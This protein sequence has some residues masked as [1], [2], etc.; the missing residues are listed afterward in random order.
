MQP[1]YLA[2]QGHNDR[3]LQ[4][5]Y[6][7]LVCRI[8]ADRYGP[9]TLPNPPRT[10]EPVRVGIV[11]GFFFEHSVW[12]MPLKGWLDQLDHRRFRLFGYHTGHKQD[13]ETKAGAAFCERFVAGPLSIG[14][15]RQAILADAPHVLIYPELGMDPTCPQLAAQRLAR[16]QCTS[17]GHPDTSGFPTVDYYL[18]SDP[19][20]PADAQEHYTERLVRLPHLSSYYEPSDI[21]QATTAPPELAL[22]PTATVYLS[23]QSLFKYLPQFD[24]VFPDIAREAGDCQFVFLENRSRDVTELFRQRLQRAFAASGLQAAD[25]CL[26]MPRLDRPRFQAVMSRCHVFLDSIG[27]S[28]CN[29]ALE[30]LAYNLPLVTLPGSLMRGRHVMAM[31][32]IMGIRDTIGQTIADYIAI[33]ARLAR[34]LSWRRSISEQLRTKKHRLYRDHNSIAGLERFLE[35]AARGG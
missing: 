3:D 13:A 6:G 30:S 9:A 7:S 28:G 26:I 8:M 29:T 14:Q 17:W 22:R 18:S 4:R 32:T 1:F 2:Y 23:S 31:L 21:P 33:A 35:S 12:K 16:I 10:D 19:M 20:E 34:D 24:Y 25:Y 15:W 11:S 5:I 27:W